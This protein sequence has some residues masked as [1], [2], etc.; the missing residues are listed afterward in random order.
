MAL[1]LDFSTPI[2]VYKTLEQIG[3]DLT[4]DVVSLMMSFRTLDAS[5]RCEADG[6]KLLP[7]FCMRTRPR[8][9]QM[10]MEDMQG[11]K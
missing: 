11:I 2:A 10:S 9:P 4:S 7:S 6:L 1:Q 3:T 5:A 8:F